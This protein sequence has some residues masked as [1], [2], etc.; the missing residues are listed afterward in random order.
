MQI[1]AA[2]AARRSRTLA[3]TP[4]KLALP[5][6]ESIQK[7]KRPRFT[8]KEE[9]LIA[10]FHKNNAVPQK[11]FT[12]EE[13][14][15]IFGLYRRLC[16]ESE[17]L[18]A[19][20]KGYS[21]DEKRKEPVV[22]GIA[23]L[24]KMKSRLSNIIILANQKLVFKIAKKFEKWGTKSGFTFD[25]LVAEGNIGQIKAVEHFDLNRGCRY[26]TYATWW[27]KQGISRG[28]ADK[29]RGIR[30]PIHAQEAIGKIIRFSNEF[31]LL[32]GR[33]PSVE[34]IS[35]ATDVS[36]KKVKM[37]ATS[38]K[39]KTCELHEWIP[40]PNSCD[41]VQT[42]HLHQL[43]MRLESLFQALN[44]I[45]REIIERRFGING[46]HGKEE[47]LHE[48]A[49]DFG[50]SRERIRQ[51]EAKAILKLRSISLGMGLHI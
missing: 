40:D 32:K 26:S 5:A 1:T 13:E 41:P 12:C 33:R 25:D 45:E 3:E 46:T 2:I 24:K 42:I 23:A 15:Q 28:L 38:V 11:H 43:Q 35:K 49:I 7:R 20:L 50:L 31:C 27:I 36:E 21:A 37:L 18:E 34:E 4:L 47:T 22:S 10:A 44:P 14:A 8:K 48:I 16:N 17:K 19:E 39:E 51:I 30:L 6:H 9:M 29:E